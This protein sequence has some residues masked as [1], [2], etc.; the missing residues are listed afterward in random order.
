MVTAGPSF[1]A[2]DDGQGPHV[3]GLQHGMSF[4]ECVTGL[5]RL[6]VRGAYYIAAPYKVADQQGA[7]ARVFAIKSAGTPGIAEAS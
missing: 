4:T 7:I 2:T 3:A 5:G 1:G 6:P